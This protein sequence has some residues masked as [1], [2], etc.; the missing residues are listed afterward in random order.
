MSKLPLFGLFFPSPMSTEKVLFITFLSK[1]T[2]LIC[3]LKTP[4]TQFF[5]SSEMSPLF[6]NMLGLKLLT[7]EAVSGYLLANLHH[8]YSR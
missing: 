3:E 5:F 6:Y 2:P 4:K 7:A 1:K 8:N